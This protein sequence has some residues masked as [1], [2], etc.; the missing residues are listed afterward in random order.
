MEAPAKAAKAKT[1]V[2]AEANAE[3]RRIEALAE[4]DAIFAKLDAEA[5]GQFEVLAKKGE[6][7]REIV[8]ACGGAKEAF[9]LL[10]LEK[11]E[12]LA[13]TSSKAIANIKFDKIIVWENGGKNGRTSTANFLNGMANTLPPMMQVMRDI[14]GVELPESLVRL[15]GEDELSTQQEGNGQAK[16]EAKPEAQSEAKPDEQSATDASAAENPVTGTS[17]AKPPATEDSP[18]PPTA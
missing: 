1:I 8:E 11:L 5:R 7:L 17:K 4:A 16:A 12:T 14:G 10:L 15:S 18:T 6:G 2:D 3:Q 13:E 9:Q